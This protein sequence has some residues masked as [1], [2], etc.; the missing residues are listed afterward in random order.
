MFA[1]NASYRLKR[2]PPFFSDVQSVTTSVVGILAPLD[3]SS[4]LH[5]VDKDHQSTW[6]HSENR[7]ERLLGNSRGRVEDPQDAGMPWGR[8][9]VSPVGRQT[10]MQHKHPLAQL[11]IH[12]ARINKQKRRVKYGTGGDSM[13][14]RWALVTGASSCIASEFARE[15]AQRGHP[16]LAVARTARTARGT[17]KTSG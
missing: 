7:G 15:L 9:S 3:Y 4:L 16:V 11:E 2:R 1:G 14:K 10:A 17:V 12:R 8:A 5:F 6:N 13:S